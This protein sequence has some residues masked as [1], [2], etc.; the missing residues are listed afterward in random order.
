MTSSAAELG[1]APGSW[2]TPTSGQC[3]R[4]TACAQ[5]QL[6]CTAQKGWGHDHQEMGRREE[7]ELT[8]CVAQ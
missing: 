1:Q 8:G 3:C 2:G 6:F 4:E 5:E 7:R